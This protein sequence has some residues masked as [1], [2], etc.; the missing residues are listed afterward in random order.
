MIEEIPLPVTDDPVDA[1]FW[2]GARNGKLLVQSCSQCRQRRFPPRPMCPYCQSEQC[3]WQELSGRGTI[4]S[5]TMPRSP[6]LPAF[7]KLMPYVVALV[8]LE[9][10]R[11]L[12]MIG[13]LLT[14]EEGEIQG[15]ENA[16]IGVSVKAVFKP[17]SD[18]VSLVCWVPVS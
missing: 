3:E 11:G 16:A 5:Y 4:W 9:E 13:P 1:E 8:E 7:E 15:V 14:A 18:D 2:R 17:Y 12:R 10:E 6:L